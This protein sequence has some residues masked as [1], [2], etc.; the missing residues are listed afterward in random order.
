MTW[1]EAVQHFRSQPQNSQ[2][3]TDAYL[4]ED[5]V[6]N[7][8]RF[9]SSEEYIETKNK[10]YQHQGKKD[11]LHI[12][13]IGAGNGIATISFAL[14]GFKVT[15]LEPDKS[16]TVGS[17]AIRKLKEHFNLSNVEIVEAFGENLPFSDNNFDVVYGRQVMHHA[18]NLDG[19]VKE[20]ARVLKPGGVF[21]TTRDH[22]VSNER[23]KAEFLKRHPFQELYGGEN[24]FSVEQYS[25]A[26]NKAGLHISE[27]LLPKQSVI[28]YAPWDINRAT[29]ELKKRLSPLHKI[30]PLVLLFRL[31]ILARLQR[32]PGRL[33]SFVAI[34]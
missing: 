5:L 17:G 32:I 18:H 6:R 15:A 26:I 34:K 23:E 10:I 9:S 30:K 21:I 3:V 8:E 4:E 2:L 20:L 33:Y 7:I 22:V 29:L 14:D 27:V 1:E 28:N 19:F 11:D 12:L 25:S 13:D 24:A 31:F 16:N